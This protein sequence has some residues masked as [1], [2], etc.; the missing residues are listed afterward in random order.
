M[1]NLG[2]VLLYIATALGVILM[3]GGWRETERPAK[4]QTWTYA[5]MT[6]C[7]VAATL[8]LLYLFLAHDFEYSYVYGYS[9]RDLP[10]GYLVSSLWAGQEG[11]FLIWAF[12]GAILGLFLLG[13]RGPLA[14]QTL[15]FFVVTQLFLL[16][17][18]IVKSPFAVQ[19]PVPPDGRG[20]NPLLQ[21]P[22]MVIHPPIIFI[23]Y[24]A[25][26]IPFA[27]AMAAMISRRFEN[28]AATVFPWVAF[29]VASLGAGIFIGGF[30]AYKVLGWG[31][32]WGW[33]PVENASLIPW[34]T[35]LALLHG[36]ILFRVQPKLLKTNLGL[37]LISYLLVVYG[38]FLTRSGVLADFS[39]HSFADLGINAYLIVY[40][41]GIT[42]ISLVLLAVRTAKV[43]TIPISRAVN[44]REFG[45]VF[46]LLLLLITAGLVLVGT[47]APLLTGIGGQASNVTI[48]YY[49][50]VS[51]PLGILLVLALTLSPFLI[52]GGTPW[53]DLLRQASPA[54]T[55]AS[56]ATI[57]AILLGVMQWEHLILVFGA[58]GALAS[59]LI[60]VIRFSQG[61]V[62]RMGGHLTHI[63]F[64][65]MLIG[66]LASSGYGV[67]ERLTLRPNEAQEAFGY[68]ITFRRLVKGEKLNESYLELDLVK[69]DSRIEA[70]PKLYFSDYT[71]S[72]MRNPHVVKGVFG[73]LYLAPLEHLEDDNANMVT[74]HKGEPIIVGDWTLLFT[75]FDMGAHG[76]GGGMSASAVIEAVRGGDTVQI[77]PEMVSGAGG[78][79]PIPMTIPGTEVRVSLERMQVEAQAIQ[80]S[81]IDPANAGGSS[82]EVLAL[83]I[84]TKPLVSW[85][86]AGVIVLTLGSLVSFVR[87]W[88]ESDL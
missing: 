36:L 32:Y 64:A 51:L 71:Q 20:L 1:V 75:R 65:V 27:H 15:N 62:F 19:D 63:G 43:P 21:D 40:M 73:D 23:G 9:S 88:R 66:I 2:N 28:F 46:G 53:R 77:T 29:S 17:L 69:D 11:T 44:S 67:S 14:A 70:R 34:L 79:N 6:A 80:L 8:Y 25:L 76:E 24:A 47:S 82:A 26:A 45:L 31:G 4:W 49:S 85:V 83:D 55:L 33:D 68:D 10:L 22:W 38:T 78:L 86:W 37:A 12:F 61:F 60:A 41:I 3:F 39:V 54:L 50:S 13:K 84:A 16:V 35:A 42:A 58:T 7:I 48:D 74:L 52:F 18:M 30:W 87:R 56:L 57:V 72:V 59:N 5:A 81:F